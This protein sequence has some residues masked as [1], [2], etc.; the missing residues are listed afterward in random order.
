MRK[1]M[2]NW[3]GITILLVLIAISCSGCESTAS[4]DT[5][6]E[7]THVQARVCEK[8]VGSTKEGLPVYSIMFIKQNGE[9]FNY[10]GGGDALVIRFNGAIYKTNAMTVYAMVIKDKDYMLEM[11]SDGYIVTIDGVG[12]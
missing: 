3:L 4:N 9:V 7:N 12:V 11:N 5:I 1:T 8:S 10:C 2:R 6:V